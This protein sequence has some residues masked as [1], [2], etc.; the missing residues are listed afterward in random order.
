MT[1]PGVPRLVDRPWPDVG[2][3]VVLVPV[4]STEQHGPHLPLDT[5]MV[6]ASVV[7]E[8]L[9]DRHRAEHVDAVTAPAVAFGASGEH[10]GFPGT[11]SIGTDALTALLVEL[12][13]SAGEWAERLVFV[14]GHG[15]NVEALTAAVPTLIGEGRS[16][17]WVPCT[18]GAAAVGMGVPIDAHAGRSETSLVRALDAS[19]VREDRMESGERRPIGQIMAELRAS[20][21]Q[22]VAPNGV[23]GDP[24]EA[25]AAEG[26]A[27]LAAM[28][29]DAWARLR[30]GRVD[31]R[32]CAVRGGEHGSAASVPTAG[33][34]G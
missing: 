22:H 23:L 18:P 31:A 24:R 7:A 8:A 14:N 12:G 30:S 34:I 13:R 5:D 1:V 32:G 27:L 26:E 4:G 6:I 25:S 19:R 21:V 20:G 28:M 17:V 9:V 33:A 2:R 29:A 3:P 10:R 16:V 11:L 15:G